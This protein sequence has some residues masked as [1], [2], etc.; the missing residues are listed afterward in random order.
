MIM[1]NIPIVHRLMVDEGLVKVMNA[2]LCI[3]LNR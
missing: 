3:C 2:L 1:V